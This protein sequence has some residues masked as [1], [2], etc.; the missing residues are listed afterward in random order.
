MNILNLISTRCPPFHK[1]LFLPQI[2]VL[3]K[4][5][6]VNNKTNFSQRFLCQIIQREF[7]CTAR[8]APNYASSFFLNSLPC[9]PPAALKH[10]SFF[11]HRSCCVPALCP[12]PFNLFQVLSFHQSLHWWHQRM[13]YLFFLKERWREPKERWIHTLPPSLAL[14]PH[15]RCT[16]CLAWSSQAY[17]NGA[18]ADGRES[19]RQSRWLMNNEQWRGKCSVV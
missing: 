13:H 12:S 7:P 15:I 11:P 14:S 19:H 18:V 8:P 1:V 5:S 4:Q 2:K 3:I 9:R 17:G 10:T 16:V 6:S